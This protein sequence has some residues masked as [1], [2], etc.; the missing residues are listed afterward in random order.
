MHIILGLLSVIVTILVLLNRLNRGG[1][2]IG[3]LNPFAWKRR[4]TWAKQYHANPVFALTD[5]IE[6][7]ALLL[8]A[9]AK[10]EGDMS[11]GQK[12]EM[13]RMFQDV[14]HFDEKQSS[15]QI[16]ASVFLLKEEVDLVSNMGK[17]IEPSRSF[18]S[19][20]QSTSALELLKEMSRLERAPNEY[21]M[22]LIKAFESAMSVH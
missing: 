1:I 17:F 20:S 13:L 15:E 19:G 3:W 18:F 9:L 4:R 22:S 2:D 11:S 16:R 12:Q 14:F 5:P 7:I 21:Q 8:V 6:V 10:S